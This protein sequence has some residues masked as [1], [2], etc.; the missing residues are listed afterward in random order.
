MARH[1]K[2]GYAKPV[3]AIIPQKAAHLLRMATAYQKEKVVWSMN[4]NDSR[5]RNW[6]QRP[7]GLQFDSLVCAIFLFQ[8]NI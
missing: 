8:Q 6:Q 1:L 3:H 7:F 5:P 2:T 4:D